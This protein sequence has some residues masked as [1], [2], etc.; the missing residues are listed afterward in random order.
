MLFGV[1]LGLSGF[2]KTREQGKAVIDDFPFRLFY[3]FSAGLLFLCTALVGLQDL[4]GKSVMF[5]ILIS[6]KI[7]T[8]EIGKNISCFTDGDDA[9]DVVNQYCWVTGTHLLVN[10]SHEL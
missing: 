1:V 8:L 4:V 5:G 6:S 10:T 9:S 7:L 3:G 2:F